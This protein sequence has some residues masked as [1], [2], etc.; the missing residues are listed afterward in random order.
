MSEQMP[1]G[2]PPLTVTIMRSLCAITILHPGAEGQQTLIKCLDALF[3]AYWVERK[4]TNEKGVLAEE[5]SRVLGPDETEKGGYS[6]VS[7]WPGRKLTASIVLEVA[8]KEGKEVL[9]KN[10]DR[11]LADEAFGLPWFV[12]TNARGEKESFWGVD[13][14]GQVAE[15]LGLGKPQV[16]GWK[17]VL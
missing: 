3:H 9:V 16:G 12:A 7:P 8:G 13:H 11:A 4:P 5:L 17:A 10:T 2:F 15:H 1:D 6:A 14:L